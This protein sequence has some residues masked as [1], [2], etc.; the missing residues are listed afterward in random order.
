AKIR[1][2][3]IEPREVELALMAHPQ[4]REA[5]VVLRQDGAGERSL[6]ACV[7]L[8]DAPH[9]APELAATAAGCR[10][11]LTPLLP[12]A[13]VPASASGGELA[14]LPNGKLDRRS[15]AL[16]TPVAALARTVGAPRTPLEELLADI[17]AEVLGEDRIDVEESF[18]AL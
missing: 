4:V 15:L 9:T 18:F 14:R 16:W 7:V 3:R 10:A 13:R 2:H 1:G 17:F 12:P 11:P 8:R 5:A 6:L